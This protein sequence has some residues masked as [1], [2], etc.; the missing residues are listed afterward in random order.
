VLDPAA[1]KVGRIEQLAYPPHRKDRPLANLF[2][3]EAER[4]KIGLEGKTVH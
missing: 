1:L 3:A 4:L 2:V